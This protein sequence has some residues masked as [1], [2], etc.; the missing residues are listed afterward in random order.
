[1]SEPEPTPTRRP[2]PHRPTAALIVA[3]LALVVAAAPP[4]YAALKANSVGSRQIVNHSVSG[5]D[6]KANAVTSGHVANSSLG[7][8]D[9]AGLVLRRLVPLDLSSCPSGPLGRPGGPVALAA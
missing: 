1:M 6:I 8:A 2:R 7:L 4:A 5:A 3:S 9:L